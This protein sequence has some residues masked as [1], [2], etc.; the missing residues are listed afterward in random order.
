MGVLEVDF[1]APLAA[2]LFERGDRDAKPIRE[3]VGESLRWSGFRID[4][5]ANRNVIDIEGRLSTEDSVM[6]AWVIP[7]EEGLQIAHECCQAMPEN[8]PG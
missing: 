8:G 5:D 6:Q 7:V 1:D 2:R 3:R 4:S